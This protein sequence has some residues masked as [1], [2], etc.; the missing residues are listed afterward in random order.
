M[1]TDYGSCDL[2]FKRGVNPQYLAPIMW[3]AIDGAREVF[4][5]LGVGLVITSGVDGR[6]SRNSRHSYGLAIDVRR[7]HLVDVLSIVGE[8]RTALGSAFQVVL[9][10]THIHIEYD[11]A[12]G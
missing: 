3:V 11:P 7:R 1:N 12:G 4:D 10:D 9:E 6:H 2:A 8:L 5:R